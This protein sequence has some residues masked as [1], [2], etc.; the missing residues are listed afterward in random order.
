MN[1][2]SQVAVNQ[3]IGRG[4][5]VLACFVAYQLVMHPDSQVLLL[6]GAGL[7]VL[8][9]VLRPVL[10][11][12]LYLLIYPL[13]PAEES[14]NALK[15]AML[16]LT[17]LLVLVWLMQKMIKRER[18]STKPEYLWLYLFFVFLCFS[19]LLG[20][21]GDFSPTD[22]ARDIAPLLN[23]LLLPV[24]ADCIGKEKNRWLL[25]IVF[26]PIGFGILRDMLVLLGGYGVAG[27]G[28]LTSLP[29]A[30]IH[31]S[32]GLGLGLLMFLRK[33]PHRRYWLA[34]AVLS[35][36]VALLTPTRTVW[37]TTGT[38]ILLVSAFNLQKKRWVIAS[39]V[40]LVVLLGV[41]FFAKGSDTYERSQRERFE[42]LVEYKTN[43]SYQNRM[44]E[45]EQAWELFLSSPV[46]GVGF[47]YQYNFSRSFITG[48][49]RGI[50]ST[51]FTHN[52]IMFILS[53]GGLIG[54][55]L[56]VFMLYGLLRKLVQQRREKQGTLQSTWATVAILALVNST[57]I[58][59]S[60]P[61]FQTRSATFSLAILLA[62]GLARREHASAR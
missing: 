38:M 10:G 48:I 47:G 36:V 4:L 32:L 20:I 5:L 13:V 62:M 37:I 2:K 31:P 41:L 51:N 29:F 58:G 27:G 56:F 26:V 30:S 40:I 22:W 7:A 59:L 11:L 23:L 6:L 60:T 42:G 25:Y 18:L 45:S 12:A 33:A 9:V 50:L 15:A 3:A 54:I 44:E 34:M 49:G 35:L 53:K 39:V 61:V 43:L 21:Y 16:G 24:I 14:L 55:T 46:Y 28:L 1:V 19:P 52:D 8:V 17:V 57:I